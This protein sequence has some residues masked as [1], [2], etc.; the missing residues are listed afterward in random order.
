MD[1]PEGLDEWDV[2]CSKSHLWTV[3]RV[4]IT[5]YCLQ[6]NPGRIIARTGSFDVTLTAPASLEAGGIM[7]IITTDNNNN[8]NNNQV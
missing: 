7:I 3:E 1:C 6:I 4:V 8:N 2:L 5:L